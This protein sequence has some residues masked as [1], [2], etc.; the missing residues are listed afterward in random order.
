MLRFLTSLVIM[1]A[2]NA[3]GLLAAVAL[4]PDFRVDA[5]GFILA[6]AV[7]SIVEVFGNPL[8]AKISI[9]YVPALR[10]SFALVTSFVGV[11]LIDLLLDGVSVPNLRTW[12]LT[13][14]IIWAGALVATLILPFLFVKKAVGR[15][16]A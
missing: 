6:V 15:T 14:L 10:G 11:W 8:L 2:G 4:L 3:A 7:L 9:K 5:T 12:L 13:A 1:V 16:S